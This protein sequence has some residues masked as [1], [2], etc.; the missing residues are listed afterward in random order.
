MVTG[1]DWLGFGFDATE[2]VA[3]L[4]FAYRCARNND[5]NRQHI[6]ALELRVKALEASTD[7]E[8]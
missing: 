8:R 5:R 3:I 6:R 7:A 4:A 2:M 1:V